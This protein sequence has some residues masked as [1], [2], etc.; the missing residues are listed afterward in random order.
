MVDHT[1]LLPRIFR[2]RF[3]RDF[4]TGIA[5]TTTELTPFEDTSAES[6]SQG[7]GQVRCK[8]CR[9]VL[10][11]AASAIAAGGAHEH[12]FRNPQGYSFAVRCFQ[13]ADG[14]VSAGDPM[15]K[16][17]W[18]PGYAYTFAV[19][20]NCGEH[21]GWFYFGGGPTFVGLIATRIK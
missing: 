21:L 10:T 20:G 2:Q 18:F 12:N 14:C 13:E 3:N 1:A 15:D 17:C 19:C 4:S 5:G 11:K 9:T 6:A 7:D 8:K 16:D